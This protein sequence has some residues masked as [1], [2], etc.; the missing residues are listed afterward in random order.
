M[1]LFAFSI[2]KAQEVWTLKTTD[3]IKVYNGIAGASK[4]KPIKIECTFNATAAQLAT[5]LLDIK[6]YPEWVYH[7][8]LTSLIKQESPAELYYY[9]EINMPWPAHNRDFA[10]HV[11]VSQNTATKVVTVEAPSVPG[12]VPEKEGIARIHQSHG[13]WIITPLGSNQ[14]SVVYFLEINPGG[15]APAW[16]I[17]TFLAEGPLQSFKNLKQQVQKAAYKN[18]PLPF[19]RN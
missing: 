2:A 4:I 12:L 1:L 13:K 19:I 14:V 10:A 16:L 3:G 17:N 11:S 15:A 7:T 6:N 5:V 18:A 9:A 8:K